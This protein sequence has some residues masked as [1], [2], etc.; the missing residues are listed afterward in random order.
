MKQLFNIESQKILR[1]VQINGGE[2]SAQKTK[3]YLIAAKKN[4]KKEY[5]AD[6]LLWFRKALRLQFTPKKKVK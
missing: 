1:E 3:G 2:D 4:S 5:N 6:S